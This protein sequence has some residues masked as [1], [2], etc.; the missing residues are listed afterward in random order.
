MPYVQRDAADQEQESGKDEAMNETMK[1]M[2]SQ[3]SVPL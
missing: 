1:T 3:L 2:S